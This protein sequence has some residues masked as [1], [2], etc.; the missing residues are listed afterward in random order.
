M[1]NYIIMITAFNDYHFVSI[2][3]VTLQKKIGTKRVIEDATSEA[4]SFC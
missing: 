4:E 2:L 1:R 3:K